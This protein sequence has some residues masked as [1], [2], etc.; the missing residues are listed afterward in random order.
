VE[1]SYTTLIQFFG[2]PFVP[3]ETKLDVAWDVEF[4]DGTV[5]TIYNW[6]NGKRY[7]GEKEGLALHEIKQWNVGGYDAKAVEYV[8]HLVT[9]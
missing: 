4:E 8:K 1:C 6:K 7:L 3:F 5:A 2:E 9:K